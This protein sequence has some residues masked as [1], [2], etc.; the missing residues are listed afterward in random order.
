[1]NSRLLPDKN[2]ISSDVHFWHKPQKTSLSS[3]P[4]QRRQIGAR[5]SPPVSTAVL[6]YKILM[7]SYTAAVVEA[8]VDDTGKVKIHRVIVG[9]DCG[10]VANPD[11]VRAQVEG[12]VVYG[13]TAALY[14]EIT[15][16]D[17]RVEQSNFH[18]YPMMLIA[19]MPK[20]EVVLAPSG[21]FWGGAGEPAMAP[22]A[23][24]SV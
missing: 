14:G 23:P 13:L 17:G 20:V 24:R 1:M 7:G 4:W 22:L 3:M 9:I 2:R 6:Q 15:I 21:G 8:S 19:E 12:S 11:S 5:P 16:K 18:N 10:Y